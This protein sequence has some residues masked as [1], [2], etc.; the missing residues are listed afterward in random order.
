MPLG[1]RTQ[2][3]LLHGWCLL[4]S[5]AGVRTSHKVETVTTLLL[6]SGADT[7]HGEGNLHDSFEKLSSQCVIKSRF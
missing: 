4:F 7:S 1:L 2:R 6:M 5:M 3:F